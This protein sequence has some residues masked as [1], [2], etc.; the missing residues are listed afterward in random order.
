MDTRI[1]PTLAQISQELIA[2]KA[3]LELTEHK[4]GVNTLE[5]IINR[6]PSQ[7]SVWLRWVKASERRPD[8]PGFYYTKIFYKGSS[9]P[10]INLFTLGRWEVCDEDQEV[11]EWLDEN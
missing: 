5:D 4:V 1:N 2:L 11:Y 7:Q 6:I 8:Q 3:V 9:H 10:S